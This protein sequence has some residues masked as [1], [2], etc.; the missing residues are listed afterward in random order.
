MLSEVFIKLA[1]IVLNDLMVGTLRLW[2][3]AGTA[4]TIENLFTDSLSG[5][6]KE[7]E[8]LVFSFKEIIIILAGKRCL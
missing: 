2:A 7:N 4:A 6:R 1:V 3:C 5:R 8:V